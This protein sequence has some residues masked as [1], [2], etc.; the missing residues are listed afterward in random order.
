MGTLKPGASYVYERDGYVVY[1]REFGSSERQVIGYDYEKD[2]FERSIH[3]ED[4][5]QRKW[6]TQREEDLLWEDIRQTAK[7][8]EALQQA[9]EKVIMLYRLSKDNPK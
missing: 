6:A 4:Q 1:A 8:N 3:S 9:L 7:T 2:A 5:E